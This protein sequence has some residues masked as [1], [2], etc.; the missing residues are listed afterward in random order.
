VDRLAADVAAAEAEVAALSE[1][2]LTQQGAGSQL[3]AEVAATGIAAGT[4]PVE[5]PGLRVVVD[6]AEPDASGSTPEGGRVLD[7]DLQQVVNGLWA[8]GAEA[9]A[10]SGQRLAA[11]SAVRSA[12]DVVLVNYEP[13]FPPYRVEALGDPRRLPTAFAATD[14]GRWLQSL[15]SLY[16]V[17]ATIDPVDPGEDPIV[18]PGGPVTVRAAEPA[19]GRGSP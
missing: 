1:A 18:L 19:D 17:R 12:N 10:V 5:G 9:V 15:V 4:T 7:V 2:V 6:D 8:A 13:V 16:D 11:T 14:G 3:L